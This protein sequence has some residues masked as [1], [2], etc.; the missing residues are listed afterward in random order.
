MPCSIPL[1]APPS[2]DP[3]GFS[4]SP[5]PVRVDDILKLKELRRVER[6]G[7]RKLASAIGSVGVATVDGGVG[8]DGVLDA[9]GDSTVTLVA[10]ADLSP[11][12]E[13]VHGIL[14]LQTSSI[15]PD[16]VDVQ[17]DSLALME[18]GIIQTSC[19]AAVASSWPRVFD[20]TKAPSSYSEAIAR[21][22][23][24]AWRAA[25]AHEELSLKEMGAFEEVDLPP[26]QKTRLALSGSLPTKRML[27]ASYSLERRRLD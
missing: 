15:F 10:S 9:D 21:P 12:V 24:P 13:A 17:T 14:S 6:D 1:P 7:R 3:L 18:P 19:L 25:M 20:L 8:V 23:A 26:G 22:D 4:L 11:S 16:A 27:M 2:S 5:R